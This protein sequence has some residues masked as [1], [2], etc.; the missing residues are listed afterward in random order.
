MRPVERTDRSDQQPREAYG[1]TRTSMSLLRQRWS[2][3]HSHRSGC[4]HLGDSR[5][6]QGT[7]AL[8]R[9]LQTTH[10]HRTQ[11][12]PGARIE[13]R[14]VQLACLLDPN[15]SASREAHQPESRCEYGESRLAC[16]EQQRSA[17]RDTVTFGTPVGSRVAALVL[18]AAHQPK[19]TDGIILS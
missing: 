5:S 2:C 13:P 3:D 19:R 14:A 1:P 17:I 11:G 8:N 9:D 15:A 18:D 10:L 4:N 6:G 12:P 7:V 16:Q